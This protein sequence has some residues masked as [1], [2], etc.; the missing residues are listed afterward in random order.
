MREV[1]DLEAGAFFPGG[2]VWDGVFLASVWFWVLG[3]LVEGIEALGEVFE[4]VHFGCPWDCCLIVRV[5]CGRV[6]GLFGGISGMVTASQNHR[7]RIA[8]ER[9]I[10]F[11]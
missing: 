10:S 4:V 8:S 3:I 9:G 1:F 6:W 5:V 11:C 7:W 2:L